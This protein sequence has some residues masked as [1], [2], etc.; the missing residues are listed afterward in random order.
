MGWNCQGPLALA[1][2]STVMVRLVSIWL[3][4]ALDKR[5][6]PEPGNSFFAQRQNID[7]GHLTNVFV[8][9]DEGIAKG[10]HAQGHHRQFSQHQ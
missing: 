9:G 2:N 3:L 4:S 5:A 10:E 1:S 7:A 8:N 6:L